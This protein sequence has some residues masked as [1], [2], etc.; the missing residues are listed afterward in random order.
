MRTYTLRLCLNPS[1]DFEERMESALDFCE[2]ALIDDVM[3]FI[4]PEELH[5]GHITI[6]EAKK[7]TE[8]ILR[9]KKLLNER[10]IKVSLNPWCT[11]V[12]YD[13]GRKLKEGQNFRNMVD[14]DGTKA[15]VAVCPLDE[16]WRKYYVELLNYYVETLQPE[17]LW[18]EDDMRFSSHNPVKVG[19]FCE[20]HMQLY[21][22]RAGTSYDRDTFVKKIFSDKKARKAYL[23]VTR[24]S[25][26]DLLT[27]LTDNVKAQDSFGLMTGGNAQREAR[28]Y[29]DIFSV[30]ASNGRKKPYN[31]LCLF[32]YQQ[33]GSQ[34]YGWSF[35]SGSMFNRKMTE[36]S[37]DCVSE[38]ENFPHTMY[39]KSGNY[40]RYQLLTTAP[41][42]LVG[43]TLSIFEFT[44]NGAVHYE[45]YAKVL[46][47][48]K[49]YLSKASELELS[50]SDMVGVRV[51][52]SED[53]SYVIKA[54]SD[55][56]G[57]LSTNDSWLFAYLE[58]LGVACVYTT[59]PTIKGQ[60]VAVSGQV[61]RNYTKEEICA[62]FENNYVIITADNIEALFDMGLSYLLDIED[63][64]IYKELTDGKHSFEQINS[65]DK[66]L[67]ISKM[68]AGAQFFCGDYYNF[69]YGNEPKTVYTVMCDYS[70]NKVGEGICSV[71]NA[72]V[73]PFANITSD[74]NMPITL[75][76]PLREFAVKKALTGNKVNTHE[77]Y[78]VEEENVC[79]YVFDKGEKLHIV[80]VNFSDDDYDELHVKTPVSLETATV[81]TPEN[82]DE[83]KLAPVLGIDG[84][85]T[86]K[87]PLKGQESYVVT[88]RK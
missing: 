39:S 53:S 15:Q 32:S 71:H 49:P 7:W 76:H 31:R 34:E 2:K 41:L 21:N 22:E 38:M 56:F 13:G 84:Y 19:C 88:I 26:I 27:Y 24:E 23:D 87:E 50:P 29:Q 80:F 43:D 3:F 82:T 46:R 30:L 85:Y 6:E 51:L 1:C 61:L 65:E 86:I 75:V 35:N 73:I 5:V 42:G 67:G 63:Y 59:D 55:S 33:R 14:Y 45:R 81:F 60:V 52:V 70:E 79:V 12:H 20:K 69:R 74:R 66:I 36:K 4:A 47:E 25:F 9:A 48:V 37:A 72:L 78:F 68:R 62:L 54:K 8:L 64:E 16:N 17:T 57:A 28:H 44:G 83:K 58:Q 40:M 77:L 11:L 10:G 18:L